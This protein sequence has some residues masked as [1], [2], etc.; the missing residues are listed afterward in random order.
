MNTGDRLIEIFKTKRSKSPVPPYC[1]TL[2][3]Y[4]AGIVR[5]L[6][7]E[8]NGGEESDIFR[9]YA[10]NVPAI[11]HRYDV[12]FARSKARSRVDR[13]IE[14]LKAFQASPAQSA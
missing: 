8:K 6:E 4:P 12:A 10:D 7:K 5:S 9:V 1:V 3:V 13:S 2:P 11:K 14:I